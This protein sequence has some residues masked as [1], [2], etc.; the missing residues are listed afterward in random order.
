MGMFTAELTAARGKSGRLEQRESGRRLT[1]GGY[2]YNSTFAVEF[3]MI[4]H[5]N[6]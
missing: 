2:I 3:L 4:S 1:Q 5:C 6:N